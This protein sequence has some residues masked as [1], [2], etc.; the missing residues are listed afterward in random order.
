MEKEEVDV[1]I[2][3]AGPAGAAC[4]LGLRHY[5]D[6]RVLLLDSGDLQQVRVGE[7]VSASVFDFLNYLKVDKDQLDA[8]CFTESYGSTSYWGS[9]QA[10]EHDSLFTTAGTSYQLQRNLFDIALLKEVVAAGGHVLP[11]SRY[12]QLAQDGR[13]NWTVNAEHETRGIFQIKTQY[14]VDATGRQAHVSRK[15][16][17][18]RHKADRL[19]GVGA[20]LQLEG[21]TVRQD[22]LIEATECGW[23]YSATLPGN[24]VVVTLFSDAD[25]IS[26][27]Q[28]QKPE[29]WNHYLQQTTHTRQRLQGAG[30]T[31]TQ[32]WVKN[33]NSQ[34]S[35]GDQRA[36]F[37]AIGDAAAAF[38]PISSMGLG[39]A[40]SSACHGAKTIQAAASGNGE[41]LSIYKKDIQNSFAQYQITKQQVYGQEQRW[42]EAVFWQRRRA[43]RG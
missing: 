22:Q 25:I 11:R 21:Q 5:T 39:F 38:D 12:L 17:I 40:L 24:T 35:E 6:M 34:I 4:A 42:Q 15:L 16:G 3:G 20:F 2:I 9:G 1:L 33:A 13:L 27:H 23:W 7:H 41:A 8:D 32:L 37:I 18:Q 19:L 36:R 43:T 28:L 31:S 30:A 14:L 10:N 26:R 29:N